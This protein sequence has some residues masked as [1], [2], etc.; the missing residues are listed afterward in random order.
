MIARITLAVALTLGASPAGA[1]TGSALAVTV[2]PTV[3][4]AGESPFDGT[5]HLP[6]GVALHLGGFLHADAVAWDQSSADALDPSTGRPLNDTRFLIRRARLQARLEKDFIS[7]A[8][9]LD[10]NTVDGPTARLLAA[11]VTLRW[12]WSEG[13][14]PLVATTLGLI[15]V[16]FGAATPEEA[17]YRFNLETPTFARAYFPGEYDVGVSVHGGWKFLRYVVAAMNGDPVGEPGVGGRDVTASKDLLGRVG[18]DVSP[19]DAVR[20]QVGTSALIGEGLDPG[21]PTTKDELVWRDVNEN[22]LVELTELQVIAGS[23]ATTPQ[24]FERFAL[25]VDARVTV[26]VPVLGEAVVFGELTWASN[27]DRAIYFADPVTAGRHLRELGWSVGAYGWLGPWFRAGL[28]YDAYDPD[29]DAADGVGGVQVPADLTLSTL[30]V[31]VQWWPVDLGYIAVAY[32]H[33]D[34]ARGRAADGSVTRLPDDA[35]T[36]R[37]AIGL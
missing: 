32:D 15:K 19:V 5:L 31:V 10:G 12:P 6:G 22:G 34:N 2:T 21:T 30:S 24:T 7:G 25:G 23:A 35:L 14:I 37:A 16:P 11:D 36:V 1:Q 17:R 13:P 20:I 18:V 28:R 33:N 8:I 27:M 26:Q 9:E 29:A 4:P 3:T